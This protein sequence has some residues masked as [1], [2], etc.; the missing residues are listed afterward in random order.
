MDKEQ[1]G[2][3]CR[4]A[5]KRTVPGMVSQVQCGGFLEKGWFRWSKLGHISLKREDFSL[6]KAWK[7]LL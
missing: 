4:L 6:S 7:P 2:E 5:L 3:W 1:C